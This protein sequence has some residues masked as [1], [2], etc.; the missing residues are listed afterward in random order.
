MAG[1]GNDIVYGGDSPHSIG[2]YHLRSAA[3]TTSCSAATTSPT[4]YALAA[5]V[6]ARRFIDGGD[7]NDTIYGF[8][9]DDCLSGGE[10]T[11]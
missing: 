11:T 8:A 3:A 7:G 1:D 4:T 2:D 5:R 9:G 10:A 6:G